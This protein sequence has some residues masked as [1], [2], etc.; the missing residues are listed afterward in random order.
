MKFDEAADH[1]SAEGANSSA[2]NLAGL[3]L[4]CSNCGAYYAVDLPV[5]PICK[6]SQRV[7]LVTVGQEG[8]DSTTSRKT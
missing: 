6:C 8:S 4:P 5:C 1:G 7:D 2:S 3:G